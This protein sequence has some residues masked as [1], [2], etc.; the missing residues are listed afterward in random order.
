[1]SS[2][3]EVFRLSDTFGFPAELTAELA[4]ERGLDVDLDGYEAARERQ[5]ARSR[6]AISSGQPTA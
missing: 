6:Q 4:R 3:E 2:G 1:M 5:R